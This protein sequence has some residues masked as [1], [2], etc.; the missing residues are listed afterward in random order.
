MRM[1]AHAEIIL[2]NAYDARLGTSDHLFGLAAECAL[3]AI[4]HAHSVIPAPPAFPADKETKAKFSTH[5]N[6]LWGEYVAWADGSKTLQI[7]ATSSFDAWR[8]EDRYLHDDY[9]KPPRVDT[10]RVGAA[11]TA[12]LLER[13]ILDGVVR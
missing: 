9:F 5:I 12:E 6:K 7:P 10:H 2:H 13:L 3:K 4:L 1:R 8:A 11:T